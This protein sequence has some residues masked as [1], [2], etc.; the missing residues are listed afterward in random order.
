[1]KNCAYCGHK[2]TEDAAQCLEC[3]TPLVIAASESQTSKADAS[4]NP[5]RAAA[6]K[7][8][9]YGALWCSGGILVTVISYTSAASSPFGGNYIVA[10]GAIVFGA[11]RFF[12]GLRGRDAQ[13]KTEDIAYEALAHGTRLETQGRIQEALAVYQAI[14]EKYPQSDASKDAKKSIE[15]LP[16]KPG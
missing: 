5:A 10:W 12:Q 8:M 1:M 3:G 13:P 2:N 9:L 16:V 7:R 14:I 4:D 6:E 11:L 15:S